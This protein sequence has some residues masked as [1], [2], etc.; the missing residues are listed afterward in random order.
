M[1]GNIGRKER[2]KKKSEEGFFFLEGWL[3]RVGFERLLA[4]VELITEN[5]I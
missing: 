4:P 5:S 3:S 1:G 2:G